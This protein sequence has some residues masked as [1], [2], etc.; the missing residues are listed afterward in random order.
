M[1]QPQPHLYIPQDIKDTLIRLLS[2]FFVYWGSSSFNLHLHVSKSPVSSGLTILI[3]LKDMSNIWY[4][5]VSFLHQIMLQRPDERYKV[6]QSR[7][8]TYSLSVLQF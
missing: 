5:Y 4:Q 3:F 2:Y 8:N 1:S 6:Q 7:I